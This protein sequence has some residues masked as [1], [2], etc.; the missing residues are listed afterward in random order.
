MR[1]RLSARVCLKM[2]MARQC[3]L[4]W[5][6]MGWHGLAWPGMAWPGLARSSW[7]TAQ[8]VPQQ[9]C[10]AHDAA[11]EEK[12]Y[13]NGTLCFCSASRSAPAGGETSLPSPDHYTFQSATTLQKVPFL[14]Y[15]TVD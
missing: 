14:L 15:T 8:G 10:Q 12:G 9:F 11:V 3:W 6:G 1:R 4:A 5:P 13:L 2:K 7:A